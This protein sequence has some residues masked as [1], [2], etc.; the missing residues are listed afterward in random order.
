M[1]GRWQKTLEM[2]ACLVGMIFVL[3]ACGN[4]APD[5]GQIKK[6]MP[7]EARMIYVDSG[8]GED[9]IVLDVTG[10]NILK[11]QTNDKDDTVYCTISMEN[12]DYR[13]V[14]N[15]VLTYN[16]YDQGGWILDSWLIDEESTPAE[17]IPLN[18]IPQEKADAE[19]NNY[20][21]DSYTLHNKT[22][23]DDG[24]SIVFDYMVEY[25]DTYCSYNGRA[26]LDYYFHNEGNYA[27]WENKGVGYYD[28]WKFNI[29]G[30]WKCTSVESRGG[31]VFD[32]DINIVS[33]DEVNYTLD[34]EAIEYDRGLGGFTFNNID[35][36]TMIDT[37]DTQLDYGGSYDDNGRLI[38]S[39]EAPS[40]GF[41]L[42]CGGYLSF[43]VTFYC[44]NAIIY[45]ISNG[46]S[47]GQSKELVRSTES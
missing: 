31:D 45:P 44:D 24:K 7:E 5:E 22:F 16:Y 2:L 33:I 43:K 4:A 35:T 32:F 3:A 1:T 10:V 12:E 6:D 38:K 8:Y 28:N 11:R 30:N 26:A 40:L 14:A 15:W 27:Y 29:I 42:S 25:T 39:Y 41:T 17:I 36:Y 20:F 47:F 19:M 13:Y 46:N 21:F 9:E 37:V 18:G 23:A 34:F